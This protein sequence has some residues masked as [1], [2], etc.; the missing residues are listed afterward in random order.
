MRRTLEERAED[1]VRGIDAGDRVGE[2]GA[3]EA[4]P[5]LVHDDAQETGQR[6]RDGV[7]ARPLGVG[8]VSAEATDRA[9]DEPW[10][11]SA[12][13]LDAGAEP[14]GR[15]GP[16]VLKV[17]ISACDQ[18]VEEFAIAGLLEVAAE[19]ALVAVV[20]LEMRR[21]KPTLVAAVGIAFGALDLDHVGSEVG[22]H[23]RRRR[24]P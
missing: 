17:H 1:A 15:A 7:V 11:E 18:L 23:H 13:P 2:R 9:V 4:R 24:G 8:T 12:Q 3:E 22:K 6:L 19:T 5:L 21:I 10:V 16:E 14:L 20:G